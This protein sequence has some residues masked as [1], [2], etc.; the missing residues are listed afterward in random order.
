[1]SKINAG[2]M[3]T[4]GFLHSQPWPGSTPLGAS[5]RYLLYH[6]CSSSSPSGDCAAVIWRAM[7]RQGDGE[8][9]TFLVSS[10]HAVAG[11]W[12]ESAKADE[13]KAKGYPPSGPNVDQRDWDHCKAGRDWR[14]RGNSENL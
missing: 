10:D 12:R 13:P 3:N 7:L 2:M 4:K 8:D 14:M 9:R 5:G 1:L 11:A 6:A